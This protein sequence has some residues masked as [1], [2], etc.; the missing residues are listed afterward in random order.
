MIYI[1][2]LVG[3]VA[4]GIPMCRNKIGKI[5]YCVLAGIAFFVI[6][7]IR[8]NVGFDYPSYARLYMDSASYSLD[9][10]AVGRMEKGYFVIEKLLADYFPDYQAIFIVTS[11]IFAVAI[12]YIVYK[13]CERPYLGFAFFLTYGIYFNTLNFLRQMIAGFIMLLGMKYIKKNQFFRYLL[14]VLFATCFHRSALIMIPMYFIL[15]IKMCPTSL[16]I[17]SG[18]VI[19]F[20]VFSWDLMEFVSQFLVAYKHYALR[21]NIHLTDGV[22]PTFMIFIGITFIVAF[23]FR[24]RLIEKDPFN[25]VYLNCLFLTFAFEVIGVKHSIVTRLGVFFVIPGV[26]LLL[27]ILFDVILE[28]AK[29]KSRKRNRR[30]RK[31]LTVY[32]AVAVSAVVVF[33]SVMYGCLLATNYNHVLSYQTI[34]NPWDLKEASE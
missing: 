2:L 29:E 21:S 32:T 19:L 23:L 1:L 6:A 3:I 10:I 28:W 25:N 31:K 26:I 34:F 30:D 18:L 27:P 8:W 20:L 9:D 12:A 33:N 22:D 4:A 24:K 17:Y 14:L 7:A 11:A 13:E 15:R 5:A 16:G